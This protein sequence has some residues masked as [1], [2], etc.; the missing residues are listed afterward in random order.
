M[1]GS[2]FF[3]DFSMKY[4]LCCITSLL[5]L[6]GTAFA[7]PDIAEIREMAY[8]CEAMNGHGLADPP[9]PLP[10]TVP[11]DPN[12]PSGEKWV[13]KAEGKAEKQGSM[14][15]G[16]NRYGN[17]WAVYQRGGSK[18]YAIIVRG[19]V[20]DKSVNLLRQRSVL[21]DA[22][23][24]TVG[25]SQVNFSFIDPSE[26]KD[27]SKRGVIQL[28]LDDKASVHIGFAYGLVDI[29]LHENGQ[30]LVKY[31][32]TLPDSSEL[33]ITGHSQGAG[34][35]T[36]L[37]AFLHYSGSPNNKQY[38]LA[39]KGFKLRSYVFAQP[40][41]GDWRFLLDFTRNIA[42][43]TSGE[44]AYVINNVND[45]VPQVPLTIQ[46]LTS[47]PLSAFLDPPSSATNGA[48]AYIA[49]S[50]GFRELLSRT[51]IVSQGLHDPVT[52]HRVWN[53]C[54]KLLPDDVTK[55][56]LSDVISLRK[57][58]AIKD[59]ALGLQGMATTVSSSIASGSFAGFNDLD[60]SFF[61]DGRQPQGDG[62]VLGAESITYM[63]V[64]TLYALP[65]CNPRSNSGTS[66]RDYFLEHH[67]ATYIDLLSDY[68][69]QNKDP[70]KCRFSP[71]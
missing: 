57:L 1:I 38:G 13:W 12:Q 10:Q 14:Y 71:L 32:A 8:L 64:G 39:S 42:S 5:Y 46:W 30:S 65:L 60:A 45:W 53:E 62:S 23:A 59:C 24:L 26:P 11:V 37:H 54:S 4:F 33:Y 3:E 47:V 69:M 29:L 58:P 40:K 21:Q 22:L 19:T 43:E 25:A 31:L 56:S 36:L 61:T 49:A 6:C 20:L 17:R 9:G 27:S 7:A 67:M 34:I 44:S 52:G 66:S 55:I 50:T 41:P 68:N 28:A 18:R 16:F 2:G 48:K 35:A 51:M 63:P 70:A 15:W